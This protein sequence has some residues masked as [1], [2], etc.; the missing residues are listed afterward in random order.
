MH[1]HLRPVLNVWNQSVMGN[2]TNHCMHRRASSA[3]ILIAILFVVGEPGVVRG[4]NVLEADGP[5]QNL[6]SID[7]IYSTSTAQPATDA[8]LPFE[9]STLL[10]VKA[11]PKY[12]K[13]ARSIIPEKPATPSEVFT[14]NNAR[15]PWRDHLIDPRSDRDS[16][17]GRFNRARGA[18][19]RK[20]D[21]S[22]EPENI[23]FGA[24]GRP[25]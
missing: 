3:L 15:Y 23:S 6:I 14:T 2:S 21:H 10:L 4:D 12:L 17:P 25:E 7:K 20:P 19:D 18:R 8:P 11:I 16:S 9:L 1:L 22:R 5:G 24:G 13:T